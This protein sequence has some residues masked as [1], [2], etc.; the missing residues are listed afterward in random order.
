MQ[1]V[2]DAR[3]GVLAGLEIADVAFDEIEPGPL[4]CTYQGLDFV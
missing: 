1:H 4:L 3:A 2:I